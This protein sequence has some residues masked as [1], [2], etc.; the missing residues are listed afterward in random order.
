VLK[1]KICGSGRYEVIVGKTK[2]DLYNYIT[3]WADS[4]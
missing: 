1:R 2:E 4:R 3:G